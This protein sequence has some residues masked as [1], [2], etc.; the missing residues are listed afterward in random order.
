[1]KQTLSF[2]Q[3]PIKWP[4]SPQLGS[5]YRWLF[6][7]SHPICR[8][9]AFARSP[10][11]KKCKSW[12]LSRWPFAT[13]WLMLPPLYDCTGGSHALPVVE[14]DGRRAVPAFASPPRFHRRSKP[15]KKDTGPSRLYRR[16]GDGWVR[17]VFSIDPWMRASIETS[18]N[19]NHTV[20]FAPSN[21]CVLGNYLLCLRFVFV[22]LYLQLKVSAAGWL[23]CGSQA[24][25]GA[26]NHQERLGSTVTGGSVV[27]H[28]IL[29]A[30]R[31]GRPNSVLLP[32]QRV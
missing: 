14:T 5:F 2:P 3:L 20:R 26:P 16:G 18:A 10:L 30:W 29:H 28:S 22:Q 23:P 6:E 31:A 11:P 9:L 13:C 4:G 12:C 24:W 8:P 17:L 19:L 32:L 7:Y 27:V 15:S 25:I 1:M 21:N